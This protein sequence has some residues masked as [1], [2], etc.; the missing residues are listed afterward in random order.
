VTT[1]PPLSVLGDA[2]QGSKAVAFGYLAWLFLLPPLYRAVNPKQ[3][4]VQGSVTLDRMDV[5]ALFQAHFHNK[6][7]FFSVQGQKGYFTQ[8]PELP[9]QSRKVVKKPA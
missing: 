6:L 8:P 7:L 1:Y 3:K 4:D 2:L 9:E 5:I